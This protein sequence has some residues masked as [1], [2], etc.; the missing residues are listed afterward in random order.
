MLCQYV[1][2]VINRLLGMEHAVRVS[3]NSV[4]MVKTL[5]YAFNIKH[6]I[7]PH[8]DDIRYHTEPHIFLFKRNSILG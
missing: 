3:N 8:L 7:A 2:V 5:T 6:W 1:H 4:I